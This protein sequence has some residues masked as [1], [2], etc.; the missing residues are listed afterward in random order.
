MAEINNL[1]LERL[2]AKGRHPI[3]SPITPPLLVHLTQCLR[4]GT[5][6]TV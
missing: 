3:S 1:L 5:D 4:T 6:S 2:K